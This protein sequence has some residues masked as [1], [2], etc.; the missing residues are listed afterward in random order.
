MMVEAFQSELLYPRPDC[1][2]AEQRK[3]LS[4]E[5]LCQQ[6]GVC[7]DNPPVHH[8]DKWQVHLFLK[9]T[10]PVVWSDSINSGESSLRFLLEDVSV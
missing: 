3:R 7:K 10:F 1:V 8:D 5:E 4:V 9:T 2:L 6:W